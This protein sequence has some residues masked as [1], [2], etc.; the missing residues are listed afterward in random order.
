SLRDLRTGRDLVFANDRLQYANFALTDAW[1]AGG[2]EWNLGSTGHSATTS[3]PVFAARLETDRG[4]LLRLWEW[5]RTRDLVFS[6]D[7]LLAAGRPA[8]LAFVRV[9]NLDPETKPLYWWTNIAVPEEPGTRV[10]AP[11]DR[12]WRTVYDGSLTSVGIPHPDRAGVDASYPAA[13]TAAADYFFQIPARRRAW[14]AAIGADG[15]GLLQTSTDPLRGRKFFLWGRGSGGQRWQ[16]WLNGP[17]RHYLEIQAG[18]ATTQLEHRRLAGASEICWAEAYLPIKSDPAVAHAGWA[19]ATE[20]LGRGLEEALPVGELIAWRDWW[21]AEVADR[22][23][24]RV[25]AR[26]SS[27]GWVEL[28]LRGLGPDHVSGTPFEP[29]EDGLHHL[30]GLLSAGRIDQDAAGV[31]LP[32]PPTSARWKP[33]LLAAPD[34]W[35]TRLAAGIHAHAAGDPVT[36]EEH[37]RASLRARPSASARRGLAVLAA[38]RGDSGTAAAHYREAVRLEPGNLPLLT[39]AAEHLL[40]GGLAEECLACLD[41]CPPQLARHG[42]IRLQRCRAL[43]ACGR[44]DQARSILEAGLEVPDLREGE[45]LEAVWAAV[46]GDRP[47]PRAYDFRMTAG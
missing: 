37:Y 19:G 10:L 13:A 38:T 2:I 11:A 5:E 21:R 25:L 43:V 31:E 14:V 29:I 15:T 47:L 42:R 3:R 44:V 7:L 17:D 24:D 39:E 4:P 23:P 45:T 20:H 8:L 26:G 36:A 41:A 18:L 6:V 28:A 22:A 30:H 40:A 12:A 32:I 46:F 1:C 16:E 34:G 27:A 9:R 33:V 35:W